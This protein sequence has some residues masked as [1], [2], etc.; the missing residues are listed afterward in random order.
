MPL[1]RSNELAPTVAPEYYQ[2]LFAYLMQRHHDRLEKALLV[3]PLEI[4]KKYLRRHFTTGEIVPHDKAWD[5]L[6][7]YLENVES[8]L[9]RILLR[10]STAYWWHIYRRTA[11]ELHPGH[12]GKT[13]AVTAA[14]VRQ[15]TDLAIVKHSGGWREGD[16][17]SSSAVDPSTYLGG[18]YKNASIEYLGSEKAGNDLFKIATRTNQLVV[19][20]LE[21]SDFID[22]HRIEGLAYEYWKTTAALRTIGKG[23]DAE[24]TRDLWFKFHVSEDEKWLFDHYDG[25]LGRAGGFSTLFGT[26]FSGD[27]KPDD[28]DLFVWGQ[29][30]V[31]RSSKE[32]TISKIDGGAATVRF[33]PNFDIGIDKL[34]LF[35]EGHSFADAAFQRA[36]KFSL[37]AALVWIWTISIL[38]LKPEL[39]FRNQLSRS[40]EEYFESVSLLNLMKRGYIATQYD[41]DELF[42]IC[43][44][45]MDLYDLP[46][47]TPD[48]KDLGQALE[49]FTFSIE[50]KNQVGL[51]AG[52]K[53]FPIVQDGPIMV[54]DVVAIPDLIERLFFKVGDKDSAK[55][56]A[57]ESSFREYISKQKFEI[58]HFGELRWADGSKREAD[59]IVRVNNTLVVLE[60]V[61]SERPLDFEISRPKTHAKRIE[62]LKEK[63]DQASSLVDA[64]YKSPKGANFDFSWNTKVI[65]RV[66]SPHH[67]FLWSKSYPCFDD[68]GRRLIVDP[69]QCKRFLSSLASQP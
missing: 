11:P 32:V 36:N 26:W 15:I 51:W 59:A 47:D 63:I 34:S 31:E 61:S 25:E 54:F 41:R 38:F 60:C 40:E 13:D 28:Q 16:L 9:A 55:G 62:R 58:I 6:H 20:R 30:N 5:I 18:T 53:R 57:F 17:I 7:G 68:M 39:T 27:E 52:G 50:V 37:R 24:L 29:Y 14:L 1:R 19:G 2:H 35:W 22:M 21:V 12:I 42:K 46:F 48:E 44:G 10:H 45:L 23:G 43:N 66:V 33:Q 49:F 3:E 8:A 4:R 65:F 56:G 69:E 64:I 67:E